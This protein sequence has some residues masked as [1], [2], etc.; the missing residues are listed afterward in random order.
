M[1]KWLNTRFDNRNRRNANYLFSPEELIREREIERIFTEFDADGSGGLSRSEV[2]NMFQGFDIDMPL[3]K[4]DELYDSVEKNLE[5]LDLAKFK[6]CALSDR[7]NKVFTGIVNSISHEGYMPTKFTEMITYLVYLSKREE[8]VRR[9]KD[10]KGSGPNRV[11]SMSSLLK[12]REL[13]ENNK[14]VNARLA[15]LKGSLHARFRKVFLEASQNLNIS[16][17]KMD[18]ALLQ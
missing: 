7:S 13:A 12:L 16:H 2:Y 18:N 17:I 11:E 10:P 6:Q 5:E 4:L 15:K 9:I 3:E 14:E 8:L 1:I